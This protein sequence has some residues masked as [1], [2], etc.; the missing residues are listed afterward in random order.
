MNIEKM[1]KDYIKEL[2]ANIVDAK[3]MRDKTSGEASYYWAGNVAAFEI[4]LYKAKQ[5]LKIEKSARR[6]GPKTHLN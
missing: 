6:H 3:Q 5:F 2:K 1:L 4:A